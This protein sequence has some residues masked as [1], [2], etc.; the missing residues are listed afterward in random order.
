MKV[1]IVGPIATENVAHLL[2]ASAAGAPRGYTGAPILA[3]LI[4][5]MLDRGHVVVGITTDVGPDGVKAPVAVRGERL[6]MIYCPQR[7][8]AFLPHG[9]SVGRAADLFARERRF[10]CAA[11]KESKP[12]VVHAHWLKWCTHDQHGLHRPST[13]AAWAKSFGVQREKALLP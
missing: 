8:R 1:A 4:E 10:L 12:D 5:S 7:P 11:I 9:G 3:T 13:P 2:G 6:E